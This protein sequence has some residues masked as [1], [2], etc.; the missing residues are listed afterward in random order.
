MDRYPTSAVGDTQVAAGIVNSIIDPYPLRP[1]PTHGA[2]RANIESGTTTEGRSA[3]S[4]SV[5]LTNT[6]SGGARPM[7]H[8][9]ERQSG[10]SS[11]RF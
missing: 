2:G 11:M 5:V 9:K 8:L 10:R 7:P 6:F 4:T 3:R 1:Q